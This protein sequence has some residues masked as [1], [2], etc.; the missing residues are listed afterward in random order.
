VSCPDLGRESVAS[1]RERGKRRGTE[2]SNMSSC[3]LEY[4]FMW[5]QAVGMIDILT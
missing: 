5:A 1:K 2:G 4:V 3:G